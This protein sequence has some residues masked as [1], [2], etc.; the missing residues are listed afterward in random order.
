MSDE[1]YVRQNKTNH[2]N[3][4]CDVSYLSADLVATLASLDV[5]DFT[6]FCCSFFERALQISN[7]QTTR[8]H[9]WV[10]ISIRPPG[11]RSIYEEAREYSRRAYLLSGCAVSFSRCRLYWC[12][13]SNRSTTF[14]DASSTTCCDSLIDGESSTYTEF[15][16]EG[17]GLITFGK[18]SVV[19]RVAYTAKLKIMCCS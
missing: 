12:A 10:S 4:P 5:H 11:S 19:L 1:S 8:R 14:H 15:E 2:L 13:S 18:L 9:Q 17:C 16:C 3:L 6:H 7:T